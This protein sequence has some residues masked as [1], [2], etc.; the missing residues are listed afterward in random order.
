[1]DEVQSLR[2]IILRQ[3]EINDRLRA[4]LLSVN[5][6]LHGVRHQEARAMDEYE[7]T[8]LL[9]SELGITFH[10]NMESLEKGTM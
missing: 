2:D 9:L 3:K 6:Y 8:S 10:K 4:T 1:M 5:R 7:A